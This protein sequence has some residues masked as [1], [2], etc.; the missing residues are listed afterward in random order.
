L[1]G[2][3]SAEPQ[4]SPT[5]FLIYHT[6]GSLRCASQDVVAAVTG[7]RSENPVAEDSGSYNAK[8]IKGKR[9]PRRLLFPD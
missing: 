9:K 2:R 3:R 4:L 7:G 6:A 5:F 8:G 1:V